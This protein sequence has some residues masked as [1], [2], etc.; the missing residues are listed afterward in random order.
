MHTNYSQLTTSAGQ[1]SPIPRNVQTQVP[2]HW[3]TD[4]SGRLNW[5]LIKCFNWKPLLTTAEQSH[6]EANV[7]MKH[8]FGRNQFNCKKQLI[9]VGSTVYSYLIPFPTPMRTHKLN[10]TYAKNCTS[11]EKM[12]LYLVDVKVIRNSLFLPRISIQSTGADERYKSF[13]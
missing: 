1:D 3:L 13:A 2:K 5:E 6:F 4:H 11:T 10:I 8:F 9:L 7:S 12:T